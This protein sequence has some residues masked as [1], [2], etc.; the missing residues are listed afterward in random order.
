MTCNKPGVMMISFKI[1]HILKRGTN[2]VWMPCAFSFSTF[3]LFSVW[4]MV[5]LQMHD[6]SQTCFFLPHIS[7]ALSLFLVLS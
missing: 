6:N 3:L 7:L 5:E 1:T 4:I 2:R